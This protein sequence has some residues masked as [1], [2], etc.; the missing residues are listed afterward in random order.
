MSG[1]ENA[2]NKVYLDLKNKIKQYLNTEFTNFFFL[3]LALSWF[4]IKILDN[5][6]QTLNFFPNLIKFKSW[7]NINVYL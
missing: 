2:M 1:T 6:L 5:R 3:S 7:N 4:M